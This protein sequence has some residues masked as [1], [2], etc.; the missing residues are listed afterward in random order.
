M[1][2]F[3]P[4][5][6]GS[7]DSAREG[8]LPPFF[9]SCFGAWEA[10]L[11]TLSSQP[12]P[13]ASNQV[14]CLQDRSAGGWKAWESKVY[15]Y[16]FPQQPHARP[17]RGHTA[18]LYQE[19]AWYWVALFHS[20]WWPGSGNLIPTILLMSLAGSS[21]ADSGVLRHPLLFSLNSAYIFVNS[22]LIKLSNNSF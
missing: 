8:L 6:T 21:V 5:S 22:P 20:H 1:R 10:H 18:V 7:L 15:V 19:S 11:C 17:Q 3:S 12:P 4:L 13:L 14:C 16:L 2:A 9:S